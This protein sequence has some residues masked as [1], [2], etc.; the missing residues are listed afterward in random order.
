MKTD[1]CSLVDFGKVSRLRVVPLEADYCVKAL[2]RV[3]WSM[4]LIASVGLIG[5]CCSGLP[6]LKCSK[7]NEIVVSWTA[8]PD[9]NGGHSVRVCLMLIKNDNAF[10][11][12]P[13]DD[14]FDSDSSRVLELAPIGRDYFYAVPATSGE[15][16]WSLTDTANE[17]NKLYLGIIANFNQPASSGAA[18]AVIEVN[19]K[20]LPIRLTLQILSDSIVGKQSE[21]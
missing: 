15:E 1:L 19:L 10:R 17:K 6:L 7:S 11:A 12:C 21:H 14:I 3:L 8:N 16:P 9:A 4:A 13:A 18:R 5:G 20:K 2:C